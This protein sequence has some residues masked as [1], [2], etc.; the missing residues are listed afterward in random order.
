[1]SSGFP[2]PFGIGHVSSFALVVFAEVI[3]AALLALGLVTRFAAL[4]TGFNM[5]VA[6]IY[7][8]K[9]SL[10]GNHS[11]ELAFIYLAGFVTLL[12][13]GGGAFALDK[14]VFK[15]GAKKQGGGN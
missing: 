10:S 7:A 1:M 13:A 11:G 4:V 6:F 9:M 3:G 14:V 5:A 8:H 15:G 12:L 2:D